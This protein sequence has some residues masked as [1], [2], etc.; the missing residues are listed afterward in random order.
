[1][2][3]VRSL[4]HLLALVS[5]GLVHAAETPRPDLT[6]VVKGPD[7]APIAGA[8][9]MINTAAVKRGYSP[10]CPSCYADCAKSG[11]TDE[12]GRFRIASLDPELVF[13]VLVTAPHHRPVQVEKV[14]P[15][16]GEMKATLEALD[17]VKLGS[18]RYVQ[19]RVLDAE[20]K[21]LM[22]AVVTSQWFKSDKQEGLGFDS[23]DDLAVSDDEGRFTLTAK[24]PLEYLSVIVRA[25]GLAP[26]IVEKLKPKEEPREIRMDA[27]TTIAGRVVKDG[28]PVPRVQVGLVQE[29]RQA[30]QFFGDESI[31]CDDEGRFVFYNVRGDQP[32]F[33]YGMMD[34]LKSEGAMPARL[35][36]PGKSGSTLEVGDLP[37]I[38]AYTVK[39][40]VVLSEGER[41]PPGTQIMLSRE[42]AWDH[43]QVELYANGS[44]EFTG[45]AAEIHSLNVTINGWKL[46]N[47]NTSLDLYNDYS[48]VGMVSGDI[49]Q[50]RVQMAKVGTPSARRKTYAEIQKSGWDQN[51]AKQK[52]LRGMPWRAFRNVYKR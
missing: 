27:G 6:G 52:P 34:S 21:P 39:G 29:N 47:E 10:L 1:M 16:K 40:H 32:Y 20:G 31:A 14:D 3:H 30:G 22:G 49:N 44:F 9:V 41:I 12:D 19:G 43:Q 37:V 26:Q 23:V 18:E 15:A 8:T 2:R 36:H 35:I 46:A 17:L 4:F 24:D 42:D 45:V 33:I 48:L 51:K 25:R 7:G 13:T 50:L 38:P 5:C 11:R 28:K